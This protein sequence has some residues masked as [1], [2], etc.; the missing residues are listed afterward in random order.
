MAPSN[1]ARQFWLICALLSAATLAAFWP[2]LQNGFINY[3]DPDYIFLNPRVRSGLS[4][5][6]LAW[7]FTEF[8][9]GNW[10]PLTWI[11]HMLDCQWF[12]LNPRGHHCV[13]LLLHAANSLLLFGLLQRLTGAA[14]RSAIVAALFALHP[15]HVESVAWAAERKDVLSV[16]F[17]LL[18]LRAYVNWVKG[19]TFNI[20]HST[21]NVQ[22]SRCWYGWALLSFALGLMS[23]PMLVTLPL[24][25]LLLDVWPLRRLELSTLNPQPSTLNPLL[26]EKLPFFV[27][28]LASSVVTFFA[29][30]HEGAITK[31]AQV[32]IDLRM[33]NA[34]VSYANYLRQL[35][36]PTKLALYYPMPEAIPA[37]ALAAAVLVVVA[38]SVATFANFRLRPWLAAGWCWYC[39]TLLP[40]IGLVQVGLQAHADRYTYLPAIGVF[41]AVSWGLGELVASSK[42]RAMIFGTLGMAALITCGVL[43]NQQ[44]RLWRDSVTIF[45]HT[46]AVAPDNPIARLNLGSALTERGSFADAEAQ[47][48]EVVRLKPRYAEA[49]NNLGFVLAV[50]GRLDEGAERYRLAL[51]LKP[52]LARTHWL[53]AG[54]LLQQGRRADAIAEYRRTLEQDPDSPPA[55]NDLAWLLATDANEEFRNGA[56]AVTLAERLCRV[57]EFREAQFIGTL[58]AAY[59][60][61]GRFEDA[62]K[63]AQRAMDRA[64]ATGQT[65][66]VETNRRLLENYRAGRAF[67]E[68]EK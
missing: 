64:T 47:F 22:R 58:A 41:I 35:F 54:I 13:N 9:A 45:S 66:L 46:V 15:L 2:V 60:E 24:V 49:Q 61:A 31:V 34:L 56:E 59:A 52:G 48:R 21:F 28:A 12:G 38:I 11:S 20:Q 36:W 40:V 43:T 53:L 33:E 57:T 68:A 37:A 25:M 26:W 23:K 17:G 42:P 8:H 4:W 5:Q 14:W 3:D 7:A 67:H 32:A 39:V 19:Q 63:T 27:L 6:N 55:L 10:H 29:Q 50:Q 65:Q 51:Q 44:A 16:F 18:A 30:Q 1:N 62:V